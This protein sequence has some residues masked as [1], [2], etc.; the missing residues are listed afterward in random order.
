MKGLVANWE[1]RSGGQPTAPGDLLDRLMSARGLGCAASAA[2]FLNPRLT[3]LHDPSLLPG[4]DAAAARILAALHAR[5]PIAIYADYDADGVSAAAILVHIC[6]AIRPDAPVSTYIPHRLDEGYGINAAAVSEL[7]DAGARVIVSVDCGITAVGPARVARDRGVDLIITDHHECARDACDL[8]AAFSLVHPRLPGAAG[9]PSPY[10]FGDLCG[11]GVAYK[12][13]WRLATLSAGS[14]RVG[15]ALRS[16]LLDLLALASLGVIADVVPLVGE[17][18]V[19]AR[20]GLDRIKHS[21]LVGL[22]AL[23]EASGLAG[24]NVDAFDVGFKL[25][26]RLNAAGRMGHARDALEL[27]TTT[28]RERAGVLAEHLSVQNTQRQSVERSILDE[29]IALAHAAGMTAPDRRAIVLA[30]DRWHAGV[31]GIVCSRLVERFHR[32]AILLQSKPDADAGEPVCHGSARS[33]DGFDLHAALAACSHHLDKFGGHAMAAGL[34]VRQSRLGA[35]IEDF[36]R[37]C[38]DAIAPERLCARLV[39]DA[40]ASMDELTPQL[41]GRVESLAPF[42]RENPPV[43]VVVRD[44]AIAAPPRALGAHAKHLALTLAQGSGPSRRIVRTVA[45]NWGERRDALRPGM[46]LDVVVEPKLSRYNG[47][48]T[49]EPELKDAAVVG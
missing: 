37:V 44:V 34:V 8:P 23:V 46:R 47:S 29:A 11:A 27:F 13:A 5:E 19:M 33:V 32:P 25:A 10:P 6:R 18:R 42:G 39:V 20:F 43:R 1:F 14:E 31:V 4:L 45:W 3:H 16:T 30:D 48:V 24:E 15:D 7:A 26:P 21:P 49:V 36:T 38:N 41:V 35:F 40:Q 9:L 2:D 22:R 12:L 28:D 17:N